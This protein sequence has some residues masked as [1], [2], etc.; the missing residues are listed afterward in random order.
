MIPFTWN[1]R[2]GKTKLWCSLQKEGKHIII[3]VQMNTLFFI[4]VIN[5]TCSNG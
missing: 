3:K 4:E 5:T 2:K 1:S